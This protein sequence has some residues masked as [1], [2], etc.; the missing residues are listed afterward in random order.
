MTAPSSQ[1]SEVKKFNGIS[2]KDISTKRKWV[3][4]GSRTVSHS[5]GLEEAD[6]SRSSDSNSPMLNES[7]VDVPD[8]LIDHSIELFSDCLGNL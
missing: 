3:I 7:K 4:K 2:Q 6:H 5:E 8:E 1:E